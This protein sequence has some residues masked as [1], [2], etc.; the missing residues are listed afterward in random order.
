MTLKS[1]ES[2]PIFQSH[3]QTTT[4]LNETSRVL[5]W[6]KQF[7]DKPV[8]RDCLLKVKLAL[9]EGFT[10]AV[11]HAHQYK[12]ESTPVDIDAVLFS[13]RLEIRI[14]DSGQAFDLAALIATV[15]QQYPDPHNHD[16]H[17]GAT[18]FRKLSLEDGWTIEYHCPG[19]PQGQQNCLEMQILI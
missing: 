8:K 13:N 2:D 15:E 9:V 14:W 18:I 12:P 17:W 5:N 10:N 19:V 1:L 6:F 16:A 7:E 3:L 11:R 4:N